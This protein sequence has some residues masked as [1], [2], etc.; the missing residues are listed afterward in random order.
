MEDDRDVRA[1]LLSTLRMA[2][3]N[4]EEA[5]NLVLCDAI[6]FWLRHYVTDKL[7]EE[8]PETDIVKIQNDIDHE[9]SEK[10]FAKAHSSRKG[11]SCHAYK[12]IA[13]YYKQVSGKE[14]LYVPDC[15][16]DKK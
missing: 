7:P 12:Y 16:G 8:D 1:A 15:P 6:P 11:Y 4:A 13:W 10:C 9:N 2:Q 14:S 3:G 5:A